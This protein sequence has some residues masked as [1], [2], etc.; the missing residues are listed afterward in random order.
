MREWVSETTKERKG[1]G[2]GREGGREIGKRKVGN[3]A[4]MGVCE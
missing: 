2:E 1:E 4:C 3:V